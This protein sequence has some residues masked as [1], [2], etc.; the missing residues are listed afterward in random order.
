MF[1]SRLTMKILVAMSGGVDS[2]V[3]AMLLT[4]AGHE[5]VGKVIRATPEP[6]AMLLTRAGHEC[7]GCTMKLYGNADAVIECGHT[8]CSLDDV[9]DARSVA[10]RPDRPPCFT[11]GMR[12]SAAV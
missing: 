5:C 9:E 12:S 3:A 2:S 1:I 11:T 4:R 7:I 8:C 10:R 6:K